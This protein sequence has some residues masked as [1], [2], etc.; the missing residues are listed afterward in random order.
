MT[1]DIPT[2]GGPSMQDGDEPSSEEW[3]WALIGRVAHGVLHALNNSLAT[4]TMLSE[5]LRMDAAPESDLARDLKEIEESAWLAAS[6]AKKVQ[7]LGGALGRGVS[8]EPPITDVAAAVRELEFLL[9]RLLPSAATLEIDVPDSVKLPIHG[10]TLHEAVLA[11]AVEAREAL[12]GGGTFRVEMRVA[13]SSDV[14]DGAELRV[15][16]TSDGLGSAE[17]AGSRAVSHLARQLGGR[18]EVRPGPDGSG[19]VWIVAPCPKDA[20]AG[21]TTPAGGEGPDSH[22]ARR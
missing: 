2:P 16:I 21:S 14:P 17:G 12:R 1:P 4:V 13:S 11:L 8:T 22:L 6:T 7:Q 5:L 20:D 9:R 18:V 15:G 19:S 10:H 3:R